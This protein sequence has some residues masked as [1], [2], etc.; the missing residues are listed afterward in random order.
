[1]RTIIYI[2]G[3]NLY[4]GALEHTP[5]KWLNLGAFCEKLLP[6]NEINC[7]NY[8]T[9]LVEMREKDRNQRQRQIIYLRALETVP[10][11]LIFRGYFKREIKN[12]PLADRPGFEKVIKVT[13]KATDVKIATQLVHNAHQDKFDVAVLISDDS[14]LYPALHIVK[15]KLGKTTGIVSPQGKPSNL[16]SSVA[17]FTR[18]VRPQAL[19]QCQ[20]PDMLEDSEGRI[21]RKPSAW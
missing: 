19:M 1:M 10:D 4:K 2:D 3:L 14:D 18:K 15:N 20:F 5:Y 9:A 21:I 11:L 6:R 7:I 17:N 12:L 16:L 8:F 13:E